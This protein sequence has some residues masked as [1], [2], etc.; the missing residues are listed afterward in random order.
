MSCP[1]FRRC[2]STVFWHLCHR[3]RPRAA[4]D[5]AV[6]GVCVLYMLIH[7]ASS[8]SLPKPTFMRKD[9]T[10]IRKNE[11]RRNRKEFQTPNMV[12]SGS[13]CGQVVACR[14]HYGESIM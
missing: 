3:R 4:L 5:G 6:S 10:R 11:S 13:P 7:R 8:P 9:T 1:N 14:G 12:T 2:R